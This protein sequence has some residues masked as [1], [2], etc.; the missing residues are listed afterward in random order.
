[1]IPA[2]GR[3]GGAVPAVT[4]SPGLPEDRRLDCAQLRPRRFSEMVRSPRCGGSICAA[5]PDYLQPSEWL[6]RALAPGQAADLGRGSR[7]R[8]RPSARSARWARGQRRQKP[9][10]ENLGASAPWKSWVALWLDFPLQG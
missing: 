4:A 5:L 3:G 2:R 7:L 10:R 6:R 9:G 8:R 1:M